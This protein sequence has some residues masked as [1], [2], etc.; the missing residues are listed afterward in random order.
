MLIF[1]IKGFGNLIGLFWSKVLLYFGHKYDEDVIPYGQYCYKPD[2]EKNK[3][4]GKDGKF[5]YYTKSCKYYKVINKK[6]NGC[7]YYGIITDDSIFD[8]RC[9]ICNINYESD[10]EKIDN[11]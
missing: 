6:W 9:K 8:D 2:D 11:E 3:N 10:E 4:Y 1:Y 5:I 7:K